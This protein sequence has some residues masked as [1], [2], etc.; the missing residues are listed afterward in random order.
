MFRKAFMEPYTRIV[1]YYETDRMQITHH[2]NYIR[3]MEEARIDFF[4]KLGCGYRE[5]EA[6][7]VYSPVVNVS[8]EFRKTTDFGDVLKISVSVE[9]LTAVRLVLKY[10]M[11]RDGEVVTTG[12]SSHCFLDENGKF[13]KLDQAY[14]DL[15]EKLKGLKV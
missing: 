4:E 10:E 2:S 8:C 5:M 15:Y 12:S 6:G 11:T 9:K 3:F 1:N 14:P 13:V 7:G